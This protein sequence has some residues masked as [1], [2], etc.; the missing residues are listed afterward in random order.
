MAKN[1][2]V[3]GLNWDITLRE[4]ITTFQYSAAI[5]LEITRPLD[6][7]NL[8]ATLRF[9]EERRFH[10]VKR[11]LDLG[12]LAVAQENGVTCPLREIKGEIEQKT[13]TVVTN[14]TSSLND[15]IGRARRDTDMQ[16]QNEGE[17]PVL[18]N[19]NFEKMDVR[20]FCRVCNVELPS[21][22]NYT[23]HRKGKKHLKR[24]DAFDRSGKYA[25]DIQVALARGETLWQKAGQKTGTA[26][27]IQQTPMQREMKK[28]IE[29][30]PLDKF[31][32]I[33]GITLTSPVVCLSHYIGKNHIKKAALNSQ[34]DNHGDIV[35]GVFMYIGP[36]LRSRFPGDMGQWASQKCVCQL[37]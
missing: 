2:V 36:F 20:R 12:N 8:R 17:L 4:L 32:P 24:Q 7:A 29:N 10:D 23:M 1:I 25:D 13:N 16:G 3:E 18:Q 30:Q 28:L 35:K 9:C 19:G 22:T 15:L 27:V 37:A 11:A 21:I 5:Q 14:D 33:C 26:S 31:C 6:P 34:F